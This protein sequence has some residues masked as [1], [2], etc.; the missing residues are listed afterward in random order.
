[1]QLEVILLK[2]NR[3]NRQK[4]II[5]DRDDSKQQNSK[6][7]F[8]IQI[9]TL[10]PADREYEFFSSTPRTFTK[11]TMKNIKISTN[12]KESMLSKPYTRGIK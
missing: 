6:V 8:D 10:Q 5:E 11:F 12:S 1:M 4:T 7:D 9:R 3:S 2:T